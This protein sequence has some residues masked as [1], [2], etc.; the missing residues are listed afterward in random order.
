MKWTD[1]VSEYVLLF[2]CLCANIHQ[3][4]SLNNGLLL[5]PPMVQTC[6]FSFEKLCLSNNIGMVDMG[7]IS[8]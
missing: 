2:I 7:K 5:T 6:L 8:L 3:I 1:V 4:N